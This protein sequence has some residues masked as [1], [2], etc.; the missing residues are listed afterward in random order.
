MLKEGICIH[1][2]HKTDE[3]TNQFGR[4]CRT[5]QAKLLSNFACFGFYKKVNDRFILCL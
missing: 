5:K 4:I 3:F 2:Q 1:V